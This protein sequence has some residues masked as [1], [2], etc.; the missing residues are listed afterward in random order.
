M[1]SMLE[2]NIA[3]AEEI[4]RKTEMENLEEDLEKDTKRRI[5]EEYFSRKKELIDGFLESTVV[6]LRRYIGELCQEV[7]GSIGR[8][9]VAN[10]VTRGNIKRLK[11]M[12]DKVKLLNFH[13][14]G[15]INSLLHNLE[16]EIDKFK[17]ERDSN[18]IVDSLKEIVNLSSR[19][20]C[21]DDFNTSINYLEI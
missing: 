5:A 4:R 19:E 12:I 15:E 1:P 14:D 3:H 11:K 16:T 9:K 7:L 6:E 20:L 18:V 21:H 13:N 10:K 2:S 17:G 8:Y